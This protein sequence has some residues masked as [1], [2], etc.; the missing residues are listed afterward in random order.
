MTNKDFNGWA[1]Y[2]TWNMT[3]IIE[4]DYP[5]YKIAKQCTN[6]REL[7][8]KLARAGYTKTLDGVKYSDPKIDEKEIN[9][10]LKEL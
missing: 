6:Y 2:E 5:Q 7:I 1:N 9:E 10:W 3:L 4:N 8:V